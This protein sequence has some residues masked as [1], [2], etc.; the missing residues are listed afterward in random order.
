LEER[1]AAQVG[2][3]AAADLFAPAVVGSL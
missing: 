3:A 1:R 2:G